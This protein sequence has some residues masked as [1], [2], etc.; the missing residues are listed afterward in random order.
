MQSL[1]DFLTQLGFTPA[2][3]RG[4]VGMVALFALMG[5]IAAL[6]FGGPL[7]GRLATAFVK[8]IEQG[9]AAKGR[10]PGR[11]TDAIL[12]Q[13]R[14]ERDALLE[15]VGDSALLEPII[16]HVNRLVDE[17]LPGL[18][19]RRRRLIGE[20]RSAV[21]E[22]DDDADVEAIGS[23][24]DRLR[25]TESLIRDMK[26][27]LRRIRLTTYDAQ[28]GLAQDDTRVQTALTELNELGQA[29][30]TSVA[31][32]AEDP[33]DRADRELLAELQRIDPDPQAGTE[34]DPVPRRAAPPKIG[35][36]S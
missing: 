16:V 18:L 26:S 3:I 22:N 17:E 30:R 6:M 1:I 25:K 7:F 15:T 32:T 34:S 13:F 12:K 11:A 4:I 27:A 29:I 35:N 9:P 21:N 2:D 5:L 19:K 10:R 14:K 24:Q 31:E 33:I 23:V 36:R 28:T 20:L 8:R